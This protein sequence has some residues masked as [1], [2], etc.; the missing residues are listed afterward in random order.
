M[1]SYRM[2][3]SSVLP[4]M[5]ASDVSI[6]V[7]MVN[8]VVVGQ[9]TRTRYVR[10]VTLAAVSESVAQTLMLEQ[11]DMVSAT[12]LAT[13]LVLESQSTTRERVSAP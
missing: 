8:P 6:T 3:K 13:W 7:G 9:L 1:R 5:R 4:V 11:P 12:A 10:A 2:S